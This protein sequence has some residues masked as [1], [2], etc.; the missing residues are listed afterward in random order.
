MQIKNLVPKS[1]EILLQP[2]SKEGIFYD[3]F[4]YVIENPPKNGNSSSREMD[5]GNGVNDKKYLFIVSQVQSSDPS[6]DYVPNL[7]ATFVKRELESNGDD[8]FEN[9]LK[10]T[11]ELIEGLFK[12]NTDIKLNL[13][14]TL[15]NKDKISASKIGKAKLFVYRPS[16]EEVFDVFENI[17]Q[18]SKLHIDNKRFSGII[19]GEVKKSDK[20]FFFVPDVRLSLKQK[21]IISSLSK[22]NQDAFLENFHKLAS[23]EGKQNKAPITCC[24]IHFEVEEEVKNLSDSNSNKPKA[25]KE[26]PI[27]ATEVAKINK[28]DTLI[29]TVNKFKEMIIGENSKSHNRWRLIKNRETNNYFII[30]FIALLIL[31]LI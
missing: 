24:G 14:I 31:V 23:P 15:I 8:I 21:L 3:A 1:K 19:S 27:T 28:N 5:N 9:S 30:G 2:K 22:D 29:R 4:S 17:S 26:A 11:N 25:E 18:F 12:N 20:F 7:I 13:G 10:K 16:K 6:L